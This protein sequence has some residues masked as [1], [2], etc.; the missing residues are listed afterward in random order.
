MVFFSSPSIFSNFRE[1]KSSRNISDSFI[2]NP[3]FM[4]IQSDYHEVNGIAQGLIT[5][6]RHGEYVSSSSLCSRTI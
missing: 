3:C 2:G 5:V 4:T 1:L 6:F